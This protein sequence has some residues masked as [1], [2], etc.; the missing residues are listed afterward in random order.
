MIGIHLDDIKEVAFVAHRQHRHGK[1]AL[2]ECN[3]AQPRRR[4][5]HHGH[6]SIDSAEPIMLPETINV[7][8]VRETFLGVV[9]CS[10]VQR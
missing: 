3:L 5:I 9:F 8:V 4:W 10:I 1:R 2:G 6:L 7:A